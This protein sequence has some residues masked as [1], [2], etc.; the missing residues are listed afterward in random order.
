MTQRDP[1][2]LPVMMRRDLRPSRAKLDL[3]W[4]VRLTILKIGSASL[5]PRVNVVPM[6]QIER[7]RAAAELT[8]TT[9]TLP[10]APDFC[11][12]EHAPGVQV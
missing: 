4:S 8:D 3:S 1:S 5:A 10:H 11:P 2:I 6:H 7:N 12:I 9:L